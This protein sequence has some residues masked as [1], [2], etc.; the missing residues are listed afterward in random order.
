LAS[1]LLAVPVIIYEKNYTKAMSFLTLDVLWLFTA[2]KG[3]RYAAKKQFPA[4][5]EWI[6]RSFAVTL[7]PVSAR[8]LVPVLILLYVVLHGFAL[9]DGRAA[10]IEEVLNVNAWAGLILDLAIVEWVILRSDRKR[11]TGFRG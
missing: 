1:G 3:Y 8:A 9:P 7:A 5:R 11:G 2:W 10:M 4:H 6:V